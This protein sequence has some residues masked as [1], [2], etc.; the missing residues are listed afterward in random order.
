MG[1]TEDGMTRAEVAE[2]DRL[3]DLV[4]LIRNLNQAKRIALRHSIDWLYPITVDQIDE[5][6]TRM[7]KEL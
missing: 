1:L 7:R 3:D 4:T 2:N 5:C 6:V